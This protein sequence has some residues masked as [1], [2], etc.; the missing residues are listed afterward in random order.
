MKEWTS[1][2]A[3]RGL[4]ATTKILVRSYRALRI[5]PFVSR[6]MRFRD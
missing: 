2:R 4:F 5:A 6:S 3:V 1:L